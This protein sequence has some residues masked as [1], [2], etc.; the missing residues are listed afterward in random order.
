MPQPPRD[1]RPGCSK[2]GIRFCVYVLVWSFLFNLPS[3]VSFPRPILHSFPPPFFFNSFFVHPFYPEC[4]V[5]VRRPARVPYMCTYGDTHTG[6]EVN[7]I[8]IVEILRVYVCTYERTD[9]E[10]RKKRRG[11]RVR[12]L[13]CCLLLL[14]LLP[15]SL[16]Y[17]HK[18]MRTS[19]KARVHSRNWNPPRRSKKSP[20]NRGISTALFMA[21]P[22]TCQAPK[23][24]WGQRRK[25]VPRGCS[26][27]WQCERPPARSLFPKW[28]ILEKS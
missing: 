1:N 26:E 18:T 5:C 8:L 21:L 24:G 28:E 15:S 4:R 10:E 7:Q 25:T 6:A 14:L 19:L 3:S 27:L 22:E 16:P 13:A 23:G 20:P 12:L 11:E 9:R 2:C 17:V